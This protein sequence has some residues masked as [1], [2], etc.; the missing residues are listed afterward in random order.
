MSTRS[1]INAGVVLV[2][3][4][5]GAVAAVLNVEW[6]SVSA[7]VLAAI[8]VPLGAQGALAILFAAL[9]TSVQDEIVS[10]FSVLLTA[11]TTINAAVIKPPVYL[12]VGIAV[13]LAVGT[14]LG[15]RSRVTP[16]HDPTDNTGNAL[17]P[18]PAARSMSLS[19]FQSG[20][21]SGG[22]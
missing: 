16:I 9:P 18:L 7:A 15:V 4:V 12:T 10:I 21:Q 13:L 19:R 17:V 3:V 22:E 5:L 8:L 20:G 6:L 11:A 14:A 2:G 1:I